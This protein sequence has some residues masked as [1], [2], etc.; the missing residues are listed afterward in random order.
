MAAPVEPVLPA[1][2][3]TAPAADPSLGQSL[4]TPTWLQLQAQLNMQQQLPQ[5]L[6]ALPLQVQQPPILL[7]PPPQQLLPTQ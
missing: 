3:A 7:Q 1:Q 5:P 2:P 6:Q 4:A